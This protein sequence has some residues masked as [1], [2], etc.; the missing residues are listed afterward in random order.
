MSNFFS[1][2]SPDQVMFSFKGINVTGYAKGTFID[3]EREEDSFKKQVGSLGDVT[4]TQSLNR[5]GK[6]TLTLMTAAPSN[7]ALMAV[8]AQDQQFRTGV[9]PLSI[10]DLSGNTRCRAT[11]A[12]IMKSPKVERAEESGTTVWVFECAD[13]SI[14]AGGAVT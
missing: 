13:L 6:I 1:Q 12:W 8:H 14:I 2:Y 11:E 10:K 4:R 9:G 7:D 5:S 3:C